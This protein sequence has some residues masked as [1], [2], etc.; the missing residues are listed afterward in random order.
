MTRIYDKIGSGYAGQRAEDADLLARIA[1]SLDGC[2]S[3]VNVGAGTG[4]YLSLI[5]I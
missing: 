3:V 2:D 4:S 5:H 1:E